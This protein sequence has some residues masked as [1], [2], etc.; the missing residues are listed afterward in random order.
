QG[1][2]HAGSGAERERA[3]GALGQHRSPRM[4]RPA[5]DRQP[6]PPRTRPPR[7]RQALQRRKTS[8]RTRPKTTRFANPLTYHN[9][10]DAAHTPGEP[11]RSTR[12]SDPRI[13]TRRITIEFLRPTGSRTLATPPRPRAARSGARSRSRAARRR[14]L[15][16]P[17]RPTR[18]L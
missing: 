1:H 9:N 15:H 6:P 7:L 3:H 16:R 18:F 14:V 5:A 13:R 17:R 11:T 8:P 10:L 4:P 12:R 2:P